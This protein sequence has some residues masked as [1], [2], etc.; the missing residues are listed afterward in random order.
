MS[1][2]GT[3]QAAAWSGGR[4]LARELEEEAGVRLTAPA[5]L[6][7]VHNNDAAF[8]GDHVLIYRATAWAPC[9]ATS[10]GEV[11][12]VRWFD[13]QALPDGVTRGTRARIMEAVEDQALDTLW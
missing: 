5:R 8:P 7:S 3:C 2:A 4:P 10:R 6:A 13:P 11:R 12:Q 1:R 9:H